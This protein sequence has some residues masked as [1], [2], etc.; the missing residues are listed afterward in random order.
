MGYTRIN[1]QAQ[2]Y[3][4]DFMQQ[5]VQDLLALEQDDSIIRMA[6]RYSSVDPGS[7]SNNGGT[8]GNDL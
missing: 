1:E 2:P 4:Q 7:G 5:L 8:S 6:P 3:K